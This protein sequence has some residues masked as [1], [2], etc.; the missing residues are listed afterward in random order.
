MF[1]LVVI[2]ARA[3]VR[4]RPRLW[5]NQ[6]RRRGLRLDA[7]HHLA[8]PS[9]QSS[10]SPAKEDVKEW[11]W[12]GLWLVVMGRPMMMVIIDCE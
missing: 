3:I 5:R 10:L 7:A 4:V 9:M 6:R 11:R 8:C 1:G 12:S 2:G